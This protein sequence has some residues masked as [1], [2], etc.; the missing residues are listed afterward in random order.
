MELATV[1]WELMATA[2]K[3][4]SGNNYHSSVSIQ[5]MNRRKTYAI[6]VKSSVQSHL[7]RFIACNGVKD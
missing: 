2:V 7:P 3:S 5:S 1:K 6:N 4:E